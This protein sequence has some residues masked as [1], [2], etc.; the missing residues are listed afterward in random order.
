MKEIDW[1][2][3]LVLHEKKSM[4]KAA[5]ALFMTQSAL[6][7]R[8]RAMEEEWNVE[9]V[10]R[11]SQGVIF[12]EEGRYLVK[13][14]S[15]MLD[16][17]KEIENHFSQ[18]SRKKE[19]LKIGVPNSFARI[20]MAELLKQY[21]ES[22]NKIQIITVPNSSDMII[23]QLTNESVDMGIICGDYPFIGEKTCLFREELYLIT[24]KNVGLEEIESMTLIESY[25]NPLV[26]L[27][28][29]QWWN[30]HFGSM[31][32]ETAK[33]PYADIA[34]EMV[35]KGLG[36]TFVFGDGWKVDSQKVQRLSIHDGKGHSVNRNVWLMLSDHCQNSEDKMEFAD[37]I[38]NYYK[39]Q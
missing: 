27:T 9:I 32:R 2:I 14:S 22:S 37:F 25:L 26:K 15:I 28:V 38:R 5:E 36:V 10:K 12:T 20:H 11:S 19:L 35:E 39:V 31:P 16:F 21:I 6:T 1:R 7:K 8:V 4:T 34:I 33:V 13:K 17:L 3:L 18:N 30:H 29:D 24:P 23:Q